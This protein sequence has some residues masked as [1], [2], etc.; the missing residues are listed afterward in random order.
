M[1][2]QTT[3]QG[4]T[5]TLTAYDHATEKI[6]QREVWQSSV[7]ISLP[8]ATRIRLARWLLGREYRAII[9]AREAD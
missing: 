2:V 3:W 6:C 1:R 9:R 5:L 4:N 8:F 7:F